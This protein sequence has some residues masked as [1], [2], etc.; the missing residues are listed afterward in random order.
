MKNKKKLFVIDLGHL[1]R[2][3]LIVSFDIFSDIF[4]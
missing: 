2:F 4:N 3:I 1:Q